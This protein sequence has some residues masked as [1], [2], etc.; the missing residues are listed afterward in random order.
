MQEKT[1]LD[2]M[3]YLNIRVYT[4]WKFLCLLLVYYY[5]HYIAIITSLYYT[6]ILNIVLLNWTPS[7]R[8]RRNYT[9]AEIIL[10]DKDNHS[11]FNSLSHN[12][13]ITH[14]STVRLNYSIKFYFY[15]L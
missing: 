14:R 3:I 9:S 7:T 13:P 1:Y 5:R 2:N 6:K 11:H 4:Q 12:R 10:F 15:L 8:R